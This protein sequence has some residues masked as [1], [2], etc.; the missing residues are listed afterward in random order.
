MP[1]QGRKAKVNSLLRSRRFWLLVAGMIAVFA[2]DVFGL[3]LETRQ[4]EEV[5]M[6]FAAWIVGDSLRETE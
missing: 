1:T 2:E 5:V 4:L 6:L 3:S